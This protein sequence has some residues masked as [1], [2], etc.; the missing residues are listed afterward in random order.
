MHASE[1]TSFL[2]AFNQEDYSS[3][4]ITNERIDL[5]KKEKKSAN[6]AVNF[7]PLFS[8]FRPRFGQR[9]LQS[10]PIILNERHRQNHPFD[11]PNRASYSLSEKFLQF[12]QFP[13]PSIVKEKC[14]VALPLTPREKSQLRIYPRTFR[15]ISLLTPL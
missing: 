10:L 4:T 13:F 8:S 6:F 3:R 11:V 2:F 5:I 7:L 9:P 15:K 1:I 14:L 12:L